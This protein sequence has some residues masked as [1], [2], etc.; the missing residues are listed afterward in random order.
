MLHVVEKVTISAIRRL[1]AASASQFAVQ[2]TINIRLPVFRTDRMIVFLHDDTQRQLVGLVHSG[3]GG[4][5]II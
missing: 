4:E 5:M 1:R 2:K 3:N